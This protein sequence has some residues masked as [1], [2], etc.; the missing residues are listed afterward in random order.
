MPLQSILNCHQIKHFVILNIITLDIHSDRFYVN[1]FPKHE[2]YFSGMFN[3]GPLSCKV[4]AVAMYFFYM[5]SFFWMM[6]IAF[7]VCKF[8]KDFEKS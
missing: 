3:K 6:I 1:V 5:S 8:H 2:Y 7:D 4:L